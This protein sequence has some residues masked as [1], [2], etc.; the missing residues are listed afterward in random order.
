LEKGL[1]VISQLRPLAQSGQITGK[2]EP[3]KAAEPEVVPIE[4]ASEADRRARCANNLE[5][6][7][8]AM[9]R[10]RS[11]HGTFPPAYSMS[12]EAKPLLSWRVHIL[13]FLQQKALYNEFHKDES[14]D[15]PHNASLISRMPAIYTCPSESRGQATAGKTSYLTP[16]GPATI[17]P[18]A[19][20]V[21][22]QKITDGLSNTILV[23][24]AND[25]AAVIWT[26]PEDWDIAVELRAQS[27]FGHH[28]DG[29]NFAFA[30]GSALFL[31]KTIT[32]KALRALTTRN[33]AEVVSPDHPDSDNR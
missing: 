31:K 4:Q 19:E 6:I 16:R 27:L 18:G 1:E 33:G 10:Y 29:T 30:D 24:E 12:P 8:Q 15:S 28:P 14:W 22:M 21:K 13:P 17:F 2:T 20:A 9:H 26:K 7:G 25:A 32:P 5:Q 3:G 23:A 11:T